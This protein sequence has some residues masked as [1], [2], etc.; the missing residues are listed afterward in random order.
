MSQKLLLVGF[1][2]CFRPRTTAREVQTSMRRDHGIVISLS[3]ARLMLDFYLC[4]LL[5]CT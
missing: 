5:F 4:L 1:E 2:V 3:M